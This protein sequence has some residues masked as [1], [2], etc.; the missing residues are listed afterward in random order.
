MFLSTRPRRRTALIAVFTCTVLFI[1]VTIK[2]PNERFF[3]DVPDD[4]DARSDHLS[5]C[6]NLDKLSATFTELRIPE[7]THGQGGGTGERESTDCIFSIMTDIDY[8]PMAQVLGY[9]L[10]KEK[11]RGL[12]VMLIP[13]KLDRGDVREDL[14]ATGWIPVVVQP[15][16]PTKLLKDEELLHS[17]MKLHMWAFTE[18]KS[19]IYVDVPTIATKNFDELHELIKSTEISNFAA[20]LDKKSEL[21]DTAVMV[22]KPNLDEYH[23]LLKSMCNSN[24]KALTFDGI[25]SHYY[26]ESM[27][28]L[29]AKYNVDSNIWVKKSSEEWKEQQKNTKIIHYTHDKP[30]MYRDLT[31]DVFDVWYYARND[32]IEYL[33]THHTHE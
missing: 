3:A 5:H 29:P 20:L 26:S 10:I 21:V 6:S 19:I 24:N 11:S 7:G 16:Y 14:E 15:I 22:L 4:V 30:G 8:T 23:K 33:E 2:G 28:N 9:S 27:I 1:Y 31:G 13:K 12:K 32:M 18:C 25:I 17:Y